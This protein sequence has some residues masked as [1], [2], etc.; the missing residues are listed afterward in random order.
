MQTPMVTWA[1]TTGRTTRYK[2]EPD[3][4]VSGTPDLPIRAV[5]YGETFI[6]RP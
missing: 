3:G 6:L 5:K 2:I 4:D 1:L